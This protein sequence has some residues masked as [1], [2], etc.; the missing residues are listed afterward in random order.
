MSEIS[1]DDIH[2]KSESKFSIK[3]KSLDSSNESQNDDVL[4]ISTSNLLLK[5][6]LIKKK[7]IQRKIKMIQWI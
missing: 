3:L 5:S 2:A 4:F 7:I 6:N 1:E